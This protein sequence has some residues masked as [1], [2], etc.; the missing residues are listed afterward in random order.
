[1]LLSFL[2][3][4][5]IVFL[6]PKIYNLFTVRNWFL[7]KVWALTSV[8]IAAQ[9]GTMFL[10]L[11]FFHQFPVYFL[12]SNLIAV[13]AAFL[14]LYGGLALLV[15]GW[16]PLLGE[17][18][19]FLLEKLVWVLNEAMLLLES[20]PGA[21]ITRIP[22]SG[23]QAVLSYG[24]LFLVF[25]FLARKKLKYLALASVVLLVFSGSR[26]ADNF[27]A[28]AQNKLVIYAVPKA[29]VWAIFEN[30]QATVLADSAFLQNKKAQ[31]FT[32]E[33]ALLQAQVTQ[34][35]FLHWNKRMATPGKI[36]YRK[37]EEMKLLVWRGKKLLALEKTLGKNL[38]KPA[39]IDYLVLQKN[40]YFTPDKLQ[41]NFRFK[42][43]IL[44]SSNDQWYWQRA[45]KQLDQAGIP[46]HNVARHG[47]FVLTE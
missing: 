38:Q 15:L 26:M 12:F 42:K 20:W 23:W 39:E 18:V 24:F 21:V 40:V 22:F 19:G 44:D 7:D 47:A 30:Q 46:Y 45:E 29:S 13:P 11:A 27:S 36:N 28:V 17:T 8:S 32:L 10:S 3:V 1:F 43:I 37:T 33:P 2:A 9:L 5:S 25:V 34:T 14:I 4:F 35:I 6:Q 41:Q 31:D 16:V